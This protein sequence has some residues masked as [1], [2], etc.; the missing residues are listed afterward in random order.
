[1]RAW[2]C[3]RTTDG[4]ISLPTANINTAGCDR[5][6]RTV[7][8][9]CSRMPRVSRRSPRNATCCVHGTP[10]MTRRPCRAAVS[11]SP[12]SGTV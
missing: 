7:E 5:Q 9:I 4:G 11:S 3:Q 12:I 1:M 2:P 8:A 6:G 10:T